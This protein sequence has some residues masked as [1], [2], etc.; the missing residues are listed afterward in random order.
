LDV[1]GEGVEVKVGDRAVVMMP[2]EYAG[3][4]WELF[5]PESITEFAGWVR[6]HPGGIVLDIGSSIGIYSAVALFADLDVDVVAFD[7]NLGSLAAARKLCRHAAGRRLRLIHGL[8]GATSTV[9]TSLASAVAQTEDALAQTRVRGD[10]GPTRYVRLGD[11][12]TDLIPRRRLD[13]VGADLTNGREILIK[14]DVE[15]AELQVLAGG[16]ALLQRLRPHLLLSVHPCALPDY[17]HSTE[18]VRE[19][20]RE[21]HYDVRC[22][23]RDHEEHWWCAPASPD[24]ARQGADD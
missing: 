22:L 5:E 17:G 9:P 21:L 18:D 3:G 14:C 12:D 2:A 13:D 8:L 20:L 4:S 6:G 23:A 19:F 7:A 24:C 10:V 15:G 1:T 16:E 11:R